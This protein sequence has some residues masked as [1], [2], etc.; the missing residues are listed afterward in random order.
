[1]GMSRKPRS[2]SKKSA[3][4]RSPTAAVRPPRTGT[5][6]HPQARKHPETGVRARRLVEAALNIPLSYDE[7]LTFLEIGKFDETES[8]LIGGQAVAL[9]VERYSIPVP[10]ISAFRGGI[11]TDVD[12]LGGISAVVKTARRFNTKPIVREDRITDFGMD[13][14]GQLIIAPFGRREALL[15]DFLYAPIGMNPGDVCSHAISMTI[16]TRRIGILAMHPVHCLESRLL[17]LLVLPH[18]RNEQGIEQARLALKVVREHI[19]KV[20]E[21][22][23]SGERDA[24]P[25]AE[26]VFQAAGSEAGCHAAHNFGI[27]ALDSIPIDSFANRSFRAVRFP[28]MQEHVRKRL[29][30]WIGARTALEAVQRPGK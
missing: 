26:R 9:W 28:Q 20:I 8:V 29:E 4:S 24:F 27:R 3:G 22:A 1:M 23:P 12:F 11:S 7:L 14:A 6:F 17:N 5:S 25:L 15:V 13:N 18:K 10:A 30:S 2:L 19:A 21:R 16:P